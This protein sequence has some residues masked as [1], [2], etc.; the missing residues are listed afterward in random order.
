VNNIKYFSNKIEYKSECDILSKF[1]SHL[2]EN[3]IMIFTCSE[4]SSTKDISKQIKS[5]GGE[6]IDL[7]KLSSTDIKAF[8]DE[9]AIRN[10][11]LLDNNAYLKLLENSNENID[12]MIN[13]LD[14]LSLADKHIT[15]DLLKEYSQIDE[16]EDVIYDFTNALIAKNF[17]LAFNYLD[18]FL[19]DGME[20]VI[21]IG[22]I[23]SAYT[24]IY[25]IKDAINHGLSDEE[26]NEEFNYNNI[27]RVYAVKRNARYY[28]MDE[29]ENIILSLADID[30]KTKTGGD[31]VH[32]LKSYLLSL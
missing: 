24:N 22:A 16:K 5:L 4:Y 13:E 12:I 18:K 32:E 17:D 14:R 19:N 8:I 23:A 21:I 30:K 1:L 11:I 3:T 10:N 9:Y 28:T 15:L 2:D 6:Y 7:T 26:I 29:L 27:K 31:P 25:M 20:M